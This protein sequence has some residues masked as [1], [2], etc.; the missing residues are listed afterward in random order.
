MQIHL[1]E[2]EIQQA[3]LEHI[4][5]TGIPLADSNTKVTLVAGRGANGHSAVIDI[6]RI[7]QDTNTAEVNSEGSSAVSD[8]NQQAISFDFQTENDDD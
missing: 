7:T 8:K 4:N 2:T 6:E 5:N 1:N 3:L